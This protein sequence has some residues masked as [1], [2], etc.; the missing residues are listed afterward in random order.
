MS[1]EGNTAFQ[2]RLGRP[3]PCQ[4]GTPSIFRAIKITRVERASTRRAFPDPVCIC[5]KNANE[6]PLVAATAR[7]DSTKVKLRGRGAVWWTDGAPGLNRHLVKNTA[8]EWA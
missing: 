3:I 8:A 6:K 1:E 4:R 7:V 5:P 2:I